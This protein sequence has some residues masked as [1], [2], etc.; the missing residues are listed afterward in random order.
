[1]TSSDTDL[2]ALA[3]RAYAVPPAAGST[4][5]D[6]RDCRVVITGEVAAVRGTVPDSMPNWL[7]DFRVGGEVSHTHPVLGTCPAGAL[8][9]AEGLLPLIGMPRIL[10][11]HS[12]GGQVAVLLAGLLMSVNT[13]PDML[14]T[15]DAPKAGGSTLAGL[16]FTVTA[17]QYR[18]RG[19]VVTDYPVFLGQH[20][21]EPLI[22]IC[23]WIPDFIEAHSINRALAWMRANEPAASVKGAGA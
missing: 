16:L 18:F 3:E 10:T 6:W 2:C 12:L 20:V 13:P 21:R 9:A 14:V 15:F 19:S 22:D 23:D 8:S 5:V 4:V 1:M 7:R 11:G 17:R